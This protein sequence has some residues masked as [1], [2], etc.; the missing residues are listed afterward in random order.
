[1]P[2]RSRR[3]LSFYYAI[4]SQNCSSIPCKLSGPWILREKATLKHRIFT[5]TPCSFQVHSR[6]LSSKSFARI[7]FLRATRKKWAWTSF[8]NTSSRNK[9]R[10]SS[11]MRVTQNKSDRSADRKYQAIRWQ[12]QP[13]TKSSQFFPLMENRQVHRLRR[14]LLRYHHRWLTF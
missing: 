11:R 8:E 5:I 13:Q 12:P 6:N 7:K 14:S 4:Q 3:Y 10:S 9:A 2:T 1:M